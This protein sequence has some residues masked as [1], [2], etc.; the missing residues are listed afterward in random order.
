MTTMIQPLDE[1][2][3]THQV[4]TAGAQTVEKALQ[5]LAVVA[6]QDE[7]ISLMML[8]RAAGLEK[9]TT[10][11]LATALLRHGLL[12]VD[13]VTRGYSLG[14]QLV[15]L[16]QRALGQLNIAREALPYLE[17]LGALSGEA[18][19]LGLYDDGQVAYTAQIPSIHPVVIRVRVGSR[20]PLHC[21]AMGKVLLAFG[22][23]LWKEQLLARGLLPAQTPNTITEPGEL[24]EHLARVR[25]L[26]YALDDEEHRQGVRCI[27][28]PVRDHS[29]LAVA[30]ISIT[31]PAFRLARED[32]QALVRPLIETAAEFSIVLGYQPHPGGP[33][34]P[35]PSLPDDR[36]PS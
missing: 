24:V 13:P 30:A 34:A 3:A 33:L 26:G 2:D 9:T 16:A 36:V 25:R 31:G 4:R 7:P 19:H 27:G 35:P 1:A 22:P 20:V 12:R 28:A 18:V 15:G 17:R 29:G 8:S 5:V 21:T 14:L 6:A 23:A 11:R 32:L 10:R